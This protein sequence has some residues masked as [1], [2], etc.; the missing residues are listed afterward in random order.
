[1]RR[2][3]KKITKQNITILTKENFQDK[4]LIEKYKNLNT[5]HTKT[6]LIGT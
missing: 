1:M 5:Q 4:Y 6:N 3:L 2:Q